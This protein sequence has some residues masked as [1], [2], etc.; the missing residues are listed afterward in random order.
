[1]SLC[2]G[3]MGD[4]LKLLDT[5]LYLPNVDQLICIV[6]YIFKNNVFK[7]TPIVNF[8]L[9]MPSSFKTV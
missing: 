3:P 8:Y 5:F 7:S 1:M 9:R 4:V 6:L 2:D